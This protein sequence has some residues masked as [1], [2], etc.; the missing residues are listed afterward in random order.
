MSSMSTIWPASKTD[1]P[2][3]QN[4]IDFVAAGSLLRLSRRQNR[5][6][7]KSKFMKKFNVDSTV[8]MAREKYF[9]SVFQKSVVS[10]RH[11]ASARGTLRPIVTKREAGCGGRG[12]VGRDEIAG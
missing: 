1:S 11:P 6:R 8:Q 4:E 12:S 9:T 7:E 3:V 10:S 5:M 2:V